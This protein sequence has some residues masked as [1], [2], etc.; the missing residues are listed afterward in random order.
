M[1]HHIECYVATVVGEKVRL[2]MKR[3]RAVKKSNQ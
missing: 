1:W 2:R 3:H